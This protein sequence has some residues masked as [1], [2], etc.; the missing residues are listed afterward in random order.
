MA[1]TK[2]SGDKMY[3]SGRP[4]P[5]KMGRPTMPFTRICDDEVENKAVM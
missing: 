5:W 2:I 3:P 1:K 4:H